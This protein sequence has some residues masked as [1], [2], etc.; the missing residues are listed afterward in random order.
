MR[1]NRPLPPAIP[2]GRQGKRGSGRG[3]SFIC[4]RKIVATIDRLA[5]PATCCF[6]MA[7]TSGRGIGWRAQKFHDPPPPE[8]GNSRA[9]G[10]FGFAKNF[11]EIF[12]TTQVDTQKGSHSP[13]IRVTIHGGRC[14]IYQ[15]N[16]RRQMLPFS[17]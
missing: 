8:G 10:E 4:C 5:S 13:G 7:R 1:F 9:S 15:K 16:D 2:C 17:H 6:S 3:K 14:H 11:C 12:R